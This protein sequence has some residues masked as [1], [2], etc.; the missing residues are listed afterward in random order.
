M[1]RRRNHGTDS[2]GPTYFHGGVPGLR[3]GDEILPATQVPDA[4]HDYVYRSDY[5]GAA[6]H[7]DSARVYLTTH[8][9]TATSFA[10]RYLDIRTLTHH[11]GTVY[12]VRPIGKARIDPDYPHSG[13]YAPVYFYAPRATVVR[14]VA[15]DVSLSLSEQRH[16]EW[17]YVQWDDGSLIY[18][19]D[20]R[21]QMS[22][23]MRQL[24]VPQAYVDLLPP[25]TDIM[26]TL[27]PTGALYVA[28]PV[29]P[30]IPRRPI[31]DSEA[32][33]WF[34]QIDNP[35]HTIT[36]TDL[37]AYSCACGT[38]FTTGVDA[39]LHQ[40]GGETMLR[41]ICEANPQIQP[42]TLVRAARDRHPQR[43][44]WVPDVAFDK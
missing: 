6:F 15:T 24:G 40:L 13:E 43:W 42:K 29:D 18:D 4:R 3:V 12:E 16:A 1:S 9:G 2:A 8:E 32:L 21:L 23:Q 41:L 26:R 30:G 22:P 35:G 33:D 11:P 28:D 44:S 17:P 10:A 36:P 14:I 27:D 37:G 20:G 7:Y 31:T 25:W 19:Q 39:V 34:P 38:A 5:Q